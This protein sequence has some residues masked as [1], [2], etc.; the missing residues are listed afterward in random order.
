MV[1]PTALTQLRVPASSTT[2]YGPDRHSA[3]QEIK[4][5]VGTPGRGL[6]Q[7]F[8]DRLMRLEKA[9]SFCKKNEQLFLAERRGSGW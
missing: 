6:M 9:S 5:G 3:F 7:R 2:W 1:R 4:A 8:A